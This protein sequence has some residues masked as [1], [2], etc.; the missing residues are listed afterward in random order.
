ML[1]KRG[2]G[3]VKEQGNVEGSLALNTPRVVVIPADT[4][5]QARK[6][7]VAAYARVSS[8]SEDQMNSF[9]AQNA[10]YTE[11]ITSNP[12]WEFVDVYAD[13]GIT[14]TSAEKRDDFQRLLTD[15][16]RGRIDKI[17]VKSSS[18]FARNAKEC[19]EAIREL[20]ALNISVCFEEQNIDTAELS[21]ELLT[22][23]FA[24]MDQKESESISQNMRWS[25]QIRMRRGT[26][27]PATMPYGY[28]KKERPYV[29]V[30]QEANVVKKIFSD[31]LMGIGIAEI[32][33]NLNKCNTADS[34]PTHQRWTP[35]AVSRIL[36]NEK[37]AGNSLWQKTYHT[38]GF[39]TKQKNNHGEVTQ[40]YIKS[41]HVPIIAPEIFETV[42][43]LLKRRGEEYFPGREQDS[44]LNRNIVC[45][46]C[47][48]IFRKKRVRGN[49]YW[50]CRVHERNKERCEMRPLCE[51]DIKEAFLRIYHK[52]QCGKSVLDK[53]TAD[54]QAAQNGKML[55]SADIVEL[56]N[57]IADITRQD[58]LLTQLKHQG[59]VDPDIFISRRDALAEQLRAVK[60]EKERLLESE[61]NQTI[62]QTQFL[63]ETLESSPD[64]LDTFDEE[65]FRE[66]VEKIIVES[67]NRLRFRLINGLELTESIERSVR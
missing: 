67:N 4:P 66:L 39:P 64:F 45:G 51:I 40:Y 65:L 33:T 42:Q 17:L 34:L 60:L 63:L 44:P 49:M 47:G 3:I 24:M 7:R 10:H 25:Y 46:I 12:E 14:G 18:R 21:A 9:A 16:R 59:L 31:Y 8:N 11:L 48:T 6:L 28:T 61:E 53:M 15:C 13:K 22:A 58:R 23:I 19:L 2:E 41:T 52:L 37:Y 50:V 1:L 62:R 29:V 56:N 35:H 38:K 30:E 5:E 43:T 20:K 32:A 26:F 54:L 36:K 27:V 55:W 57:Q